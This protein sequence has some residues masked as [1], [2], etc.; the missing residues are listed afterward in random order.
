MMI[1]RFL[2]CFGEGA[3]QV[4]L[5]TL[6]PGFGENKLK[7]LLRSEFE[8]RFLFGGERLPAGFVI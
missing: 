4:I 1:L 3:D 8:G 5:K 7:G 6:L 2:T